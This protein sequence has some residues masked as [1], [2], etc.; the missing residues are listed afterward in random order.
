M[1]VVN[2][3]VSVMV[4]YQPVDTVILLMHGANMKIVIEVFVMPTDGC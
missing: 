2:D 1:F 4:A 3:V